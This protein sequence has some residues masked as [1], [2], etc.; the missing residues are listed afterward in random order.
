M[1]IDYVTIFK[2]SVGK[3]QV[4]LNSD[5]TTGTLYEDTYEFW[6]SLSQFFLE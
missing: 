3:I 2:K 1:Q 4:P 6:S 5:N